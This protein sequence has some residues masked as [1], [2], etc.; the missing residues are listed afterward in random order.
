LAAPRTIFYDI[1][2][3]PSLGFYFDLY[4]EG[5][6]V[7]TVQSWFML[8]FAYKVQGEKRIHYHC[9]AD[10]PGYDKNKTDD[11]ALVTDLHRL[12][13]SNAAVLVG[14]NIDRFDS[15]KSKARF[16]AHNLP[17][18]PPVKTI[19]TLK[20]ARRVFKMDSNRLAAIGEYLGLGGK[21]VTTGWKLWEACIAGDR[22]AY[23]QMGIYN[24]RDVDLL[25]QVF[26]RLAPW[27][28]NAPYLGSPGCP[29]CH[30]DRIQHRGFN[31]NKSGKSQRFQCVDC[32]HWFAG[33]CYSPK[34]AA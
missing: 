21:A 26:N 1:E 16:L 31:V 9:L 23:R 30:S 27:Q 13:F 19:D 28:P 2:T 12:V 7:S 22:A 24:R 17:P 18:P 33:K 3:A 8:S 25:E 15:R 6:I 32:G 5:N 34:V 10:Y 29:S 20:I 14:H 4:K 11:K